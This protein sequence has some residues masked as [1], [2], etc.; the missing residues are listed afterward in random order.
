MRIVSVVGTRPQLIKSAALQPVLRTRHQDVFIDTGQHYDESLAGSFFAEL[1]LAR[2]DH[3]LGIGGGGHGE[4]TGRMLVALE[5]IL[6]AERPDAVLVYGDTNSTLAGALAAAKLGIPVAHVEAGLR[7]FDRRMPEELNRVVA[8]HL[9]RWLF[10]PTPTA[11][12]NLAAEGIVD[13]VVEVGDL[14]QD[15][16][17]GCMPAVRDPELVLPGIA[18]R[19]GLPPDE[20]R[21]GGYV[22]ATIHRAENREPA[23]VR[24]WTAILATAA[25]ERPVILAL[26]P[27]TRAAV[28]AAGVVFPRAVHVVEPQG[29]RTAL[30][31]QLHAGA[32]ITDSGG[33]QRESAWLGVPCIVLRGTSEWVEAIASSDG[34]M[35]V[36]GLDPTAVAAALARVA[37]VADG[38]TAAR[39]RAATL[40]LPPAGAAAA[41]V[42][43][44]RDRYRRRSGPMS[45]VVMFVYNDATHRLAGPARGR[46]PRRGRSRG[47]G[48]GPADRRRRAAGPRPS[49]GGRSTSSGSPCPGAGAV[50][51]RRSGIR[52]GRRGILRWLLM[53]WAAVRLP[54]ELLA[55]RRSGPSGVRT[56][57]M[58]RHLAVRG[59]GLGAGRGPR[60]PRSPTSTTATTSTAWPPPLG[61]RRAHGGALVYD[62]HEIFLES[63]TYVD[64]PRW[65]RA[66]LARMERRL[67]RR[68]AA[69]VTVNDAVGAE[70]VRRLEPRRLVVVHNCPPRWEP[71]DPR[72]DRLR[73]AAGIPAGTP[74]LLYHGGFS[75][76]RGLEQLAEAS[77]L[78][79][80]SRLP[81]RLPGLR[82]P[83]VLMLDA[84]AA[85]PRYGGRL[86]VLDAVDP[87]VLLDWIATG[88]R[89]RPA[90]SS[91]RR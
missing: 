84:L 16:A 20:L 47:D 54:F 85:D 48:H 28:A 24:A 44:A 5:P 65:A 52:G 81:R 2:P 13:G 14:M 49:S 46:Q 74:V 60:G 27:G 29:Y 12:T 26:H 56:A 51:G 32:V 62:S 8:D 35:V 21:P 80:L 6:V 42:S 38:P 9:S 87:A 18:E 34:R 83:A 77:L 3:S 71:P 37:P 25:E 23:A 39:E 66:M 75:R 67:V 90:R 7:S 70:L 41:I 55:R 69:L 78:P 50:A 30:A 45:R 58:A 22:F 64:R 73:A 31:L 76:H 19:I 43:P 33:I 17:A 89:R 61:P 53:P 79:G 10:A 36:I 40:D 57:R 88:R 15:L 4:Q 82:G 11:V 59:D 86:H 91:T 63:G 72:P 1:D 68:A